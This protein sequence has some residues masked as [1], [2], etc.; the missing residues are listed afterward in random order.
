[1]KKDNIKLAIIIL[2]SALF[3]MLTQGIWGQ[4][5]YVKSA[6]MMYILWSL[7]NFLFLST[8]VEIIGSYGKMFKL[9]NLKTN[10]PTFIIN[11]IVYFAFLIFVNLYF[12]QQL[13]IR[14]NSLL[15][16][17][18]NLNILIMIMLL[19]VINLYCGQFPDS[20]EK[21]NTNIYTL[22]KKTSFK[23]GRDKFGIVIGEYTEGI[24]IGYEI[25]KY[26]D[27]KTVYKDTKNDA[28]VIKGKND[29]GNFRVS[30]QAEKSREAVKRIL[31]RAQRE[32][33]LTNG[34]INL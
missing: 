33:K 3:P 4:S 34:K 5:P 32:N 31:T 7:V 13:Y 9:E 19:Y 23:N 18:T 25:F 26:E 11:V 12:V 10:K 6:G 1:M 20:E 24:V 30:I 8:I 14:D 29:K 27:I 16:T 28:L 15:N 17:L 21:E 2:I 22:N